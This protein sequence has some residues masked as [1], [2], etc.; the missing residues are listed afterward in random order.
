MIVIIDVSIEVKID[1]ESGRAFEG[2]A[3]IEDVVD[4][5][6]RRAACAAPLLCLVARI[7]VVP[8]IRD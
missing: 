6:G 3:L 8:G 1:N 7:G 5:A 4:G 2:H